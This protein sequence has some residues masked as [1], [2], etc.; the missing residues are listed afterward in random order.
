MTTNAVGQ[1]LNAELA[2]IKQ[3]HADLVAALDRLS[4]AARSREA[5]LGDPIDLLCAKSEI[6][7]AVWQASAALETA[8]QITPPQSSSYKAA[9]IRIILRCVCGAEPHIHNSFEFVV[10]DKCGRQGPRS[11]GCPYIAVVKWND[12]V[13]GLSGELT[14]AMPAY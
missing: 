11:A 7:D 14:K 3:S 8:R 2:A 9:R 1:D 10:C 4:M 13:M 6:K 12:A 5:T